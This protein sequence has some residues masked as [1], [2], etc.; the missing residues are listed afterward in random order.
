MEKKNICIGIVILVLVSLRPA[1]S[2]VW[3]VHPDSTLN[4]IQ[5]GLNLCAA[6]DTVLVAP[7]TYYENIIWPNTQGIDLL[8]EFGPDSTIIDGS[9]TSNVVDFFQTIGY[10]N[11]VISGFT[12]QNGSASSGGGIGLYKS[13]VIIKNNHIVNCSAETF[14][15]GIAGWSSSFEAS[16]NLI[17]YNTA[18]YG[19]G[20]Y[21]NSGYNVAMKRNTISH[22]TADSIGGGIHTYVDNTTIRDNVISYNSAKS[23]GGVYCG[24]SVWLVSSSILLNTIH[25]NSAENVGAGIYCTNLTA[26]LSILFNNIDNNNEYGI[27]NEDSSVIVDAEWNWW[28]DSTGPYHPMTNPNGLG[29]WVSD[30]VDYEPWLNEPFGIEEFASTTTPS[31]F[32]LFQ[33]MPNPFNRL[34]TIR[35]QVLIPCHITLKIFDMTGRLV[36]TL[37][38]EPQ[39]HGYYNIIWDRRDSSGK[40]VTAGVY[41]YII[42]AGACTAT[43]K[44]VIL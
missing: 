22:N 42:K 23:G 41:F 37:V 27:Y 44:M 10:R 19:A 15:G 39:G 32:K 33:N 13:D 5:A 21:N 18:L 28:G 16:D 14:G 9:A 24:G 29:D 34:T 8:S 30:Y 31:T 4:S 1:Y 26:E 7:G 36:H 3:Y 38:N 11:T 25:S 20:I 35:Y 2:T 6:D 43:R 17:E 40:E 12:I